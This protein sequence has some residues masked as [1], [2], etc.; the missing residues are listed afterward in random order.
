MIWIKWFVS[1]ARCP[2]NQQVSLYLSSHSAY[3]YCADNGGCSHLCLPRLGGATCR[4]PDGA[5]D[6]CEEGR[7]QWGKEEGPANHTSPPVS[8]S[9]STSPTW[10]KHLFTRAFFSG[11]FVCFFGCVCGLL[12]LLLFCRRLFLRRHTSGPQVRR[13][14]SS[15]FFFFG[16]FRCCDL[17]IQRA[18]WIKVF[19]FPVFSD[20]KKKNHLCV[21]LVTS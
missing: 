10:I 19:F 8:L 9:L 4:C 21:L 15:F 5:N 20:K 11:C 13:S 12:L 18:D 2:P 3:N 14:S 16:E 6:W 7:S 1:I 17:N